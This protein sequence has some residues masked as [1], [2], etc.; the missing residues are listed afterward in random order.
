MNVQADSITICTICFVRVVLD[1]FKSY[2]TRQIKGMYVVNNVVRS[3][4][5]WGH[6]WHSG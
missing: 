3:I 1:I 6:R 5:R 2:S 4:F